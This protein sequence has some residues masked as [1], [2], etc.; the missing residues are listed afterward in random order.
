MT[1]N[2]A[3]IKD[4]GIYAAVHQIEQVM[5]QHNVFKGQVILQENQRRKDS[6]IYFRMTQDPENNEYDRMFPIIHFT[7][8]DILGEEFWLIPKDKLLFAYEKPTFLIRTEPGVL[9]NPKRPQ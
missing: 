6:I 9:S 3:R 1:L 4:F 7:D 2:N 5:E 8:E